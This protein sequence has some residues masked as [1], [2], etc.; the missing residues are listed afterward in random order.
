MK[1]D[2]IKTKDFGSISGNTPVTL[3]VLFGTFETATAS[4]KFKAAPLTEQ[5]C[6]H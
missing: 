3:S 4:T 6:Q 1:V 5:I 2:F